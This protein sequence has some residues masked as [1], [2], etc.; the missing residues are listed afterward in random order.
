MLVII[1]GISI[2]LEAIRGDNVPLSNPQLPLVIEEISNQFREFTASVLVQVEEEL[3]IFIG[4]R[5][6]ALLKVVRI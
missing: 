3:L 4:T 6:G 5:N 1:S 2:S